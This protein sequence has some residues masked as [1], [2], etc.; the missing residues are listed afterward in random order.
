[1]VHELK[2]DLGKGKPLYFTSKSRYINWHG[3]TN[4]LLIKRM[5]LS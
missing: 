3:C 4:E 5:A 1:M 2:D